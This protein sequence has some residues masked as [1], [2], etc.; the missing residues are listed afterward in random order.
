MVIV[1][2]TSRR[3]AN[4]H[5]I[6]APRGVSASSRVSAS[7][8][9]PIKPFSSK[10]MSSELEEIINKIDITKLKLYNK[11][12]YDM[13]KNYR[14]CKTDFEDSISKRTA[15]AI[16]IYNIAFYY[17]TKSYNTNPLLSY[18]A[19]EYYKMFAIS[20]IVNRL[21][22]PANRQRE[23]TKINEIDY[24]INDMLLNSINF[25]I[26]Y[27][28]NAIHNSS[29]SYISRK[30]AKE[31]TLCFMYVLYNCTIGT[32]ASK[33]LLR[34]IF[35]SNNNQYLLNIGIAIP[36]NSTEIESNYEKALDYIKQHGKTILKPT[37]KSRLVEL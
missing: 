29:S 22:D 11:R 3:P 9:I 7:E 34:Q 37:Y 14:T 25:I 13:I 33:D 31:L 6:S 36:N 8:N 20:H 35:F 1:G 16:L 18:Y 32:D 15:T 2:G 10:Y 5:P 4:N 24:N 17:Y 19:F 23:F 12:L 21:S 27:Y 28:G 30:H 26:G